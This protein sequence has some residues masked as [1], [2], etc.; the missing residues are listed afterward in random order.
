MRSKVSIGN[1]PVHPQLVHFPIALYTA[2]L[3]G[4]LVWAA[5]GEGFWYRASYVAGLCGGGV[6]VVAAVIGFIDL[7]GLHRDTP[8]WTSGVFHAAAAFTATILFVGAALVMRFDYVVKSGVGPFRLELPLILQ[9]LGF[10]LLLTA[11]VLGS[12]LISVFHASVLPGPDEVDNRPHAVAARLSD[13]MP[14]RR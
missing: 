12:R 1:H 14:G 13:V 11:G 9:I 6:A 7:L 10:A 3:I 4:S 8:A 2:A 5:T